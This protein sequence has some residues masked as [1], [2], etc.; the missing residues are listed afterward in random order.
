MTTTETTVR[1]G[2][3]R[4]ILIKMPMKKVNIKKATKPQKVISFSCKKGTV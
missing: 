3:K 1:N 2:R 4:K